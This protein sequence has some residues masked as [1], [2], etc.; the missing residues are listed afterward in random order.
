MIMYPVAQDTQLQR[1]KERR[2]LAISEACRVKE[3][4]AA[5]QF[6]HPRQGLPYPA[7]IRLVATFQSIRIV[8]KEKWLAVRAH[9]KK[10]RDNRTK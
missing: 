1:D 4:A 8:C 3:H 5:D 7:Y 9:R 6:L 2:L 10:V